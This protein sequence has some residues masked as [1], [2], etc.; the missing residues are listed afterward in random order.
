MA[1]IVKFN[2]NIVYGAITYVMTY[3]CN[4]NI[5]RVIRADTT[6]FCLVKYK[7]VSYSLTTA[8]IILSPATWP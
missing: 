4:R 2:V 1:Q 6:Q 7:T 3:E 8:L 5:Q